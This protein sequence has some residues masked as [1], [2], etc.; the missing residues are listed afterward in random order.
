MVTP[1]QRVK[2]GELLAVIDP[3][4][5]EIAV[6]RAE[7]ALDLAGQDVGMG[8]ACTSSRFSSN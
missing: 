2:A 3:E 1:D 7:A 8:L 4:P 5:Y 6:N